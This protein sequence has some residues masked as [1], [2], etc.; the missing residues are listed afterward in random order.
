MSFRRV[1]DTQ[2]AVNKAKHQQDNGI[3]MG[4]L[5]MREVLKKEKA[6]EIAPT[7]HEGDCTYLGDIRTL[8]GVV[9]WK[10][11]GMNDLPKDYFSENRTDLF[12]TG[13]SVSQNVG[14]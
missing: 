12:L 9:R 7:V 2:D 13:G 11:E 1:F 4:E 8:V 14:K 10:K 6:N 5:A 3:Y